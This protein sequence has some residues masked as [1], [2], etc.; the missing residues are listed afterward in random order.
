MSSEKKQSATKVLV[1]YVQKTR[2][3]EFREEIVDK[4]NLSIIDAIRC[5]LG[6]RRTRIG[7][8]VLGLMGNIGGRSESTLFGAGKKFHVRTQVECTCEQI[9]AKEVRPYPR[10]FY[11]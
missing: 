1:D 5:G 10:L 7:D 9:I 3:A 4:V 2:F 8:I 6:G 11:S